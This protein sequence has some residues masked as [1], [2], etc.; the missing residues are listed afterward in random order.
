MICEHR[1]QS[2]SIRLVIKLGTLLHKNA[3]V[4]ELYVNRSMV[5]GDGPGIEFVSNLAN[6]HDLSPIARRVYVLG[7]ALLQAICVGLGKQQPKPNF[8]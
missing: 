1:S 8:D 7:S 6:G 5:N 3:I 4:L 2:I